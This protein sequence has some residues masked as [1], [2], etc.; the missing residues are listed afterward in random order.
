MSNGCYVLFAVGISNS[1]LFNF[2][3]KSYLCWCLSIAQYVEPMY[4]GTVVEPKE[5][6][7]GS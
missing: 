5:N 6:E 3:V 2:T 4:V 1:S 7:Q